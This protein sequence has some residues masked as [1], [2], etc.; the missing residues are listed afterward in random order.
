MSTFKNLGQGKSFAL[1]NLYFYSLGLLIAETPET[2][3][4]VVAVHGSKTIK[5]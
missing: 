4:I 5:K 2:G 3:W 1:W